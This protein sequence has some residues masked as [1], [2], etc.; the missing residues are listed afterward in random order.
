[1]KQHIFLC[2]GQRVFFG[3]WSSEHGT[4]LRMVR[5][6]MSQEC[7]ERLKMGASGGCREKLH[8]G[9]GKVHDRSPVAD[10]SSKV[11]S[12][13]DEN[14]LHLPSTDEDGGFVSV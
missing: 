4:R 6:L 3:A 14:R 8:A 9:N 2:A 5:R 10:L 11:S 1:M 12:R 13:Q 7:Q